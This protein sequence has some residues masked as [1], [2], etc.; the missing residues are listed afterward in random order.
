MVGDQTDDV[1]L[2]DDSIDPGVVANNNDGT[3]F[4]LC[5]TCD[6]VG[7]CIIW[8][9]GSNAAGFRFEN[10]SYI[11]GQSLHFQRSE[12]DG[13]RQSEVRRQSETGDTHPDRI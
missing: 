2:G 7:D 9:G 10:L 4:F 6:D 12:P 5:Q 13:P 1:A 3:D 8:A 11:Q